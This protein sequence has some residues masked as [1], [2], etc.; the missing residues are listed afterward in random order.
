MQAYLTILFNVLLAAG[1]GYL[2][3]AFVLGLL[4]FWQQCDPDRREALPAEA[5]LA[6]AGTQSAKAR[7]RQVKK[8]KARQAKV[9]KAEASVK[10]KVPLQPIPLGEL[11]RSGASHQDAT[12]PENELDLV[13]RRSPADEDGEPRSAELLGA[14]P[15]TDKPQPLM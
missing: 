3:V 2:G 1:G 4:D 5:R 10:E 12:P 9:R 7:R 8:A 13:E 14:E 11:K 15:P 6:R